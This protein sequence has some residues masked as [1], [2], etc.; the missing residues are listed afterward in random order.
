M[1]I[2]GSYVSESGNESDFRYNP[3]SN[4][5][6]LRNSH[7]QQA[8]VIFLDVQSY[9][10][11]SFVP[12]VFKG[13]LNGAKGLKFW[14]GGTEAFGS[15]MDF[16]DNVWAD[17]LPGPDGVFARID[18]MLMPIITKPIG[19][20][21]TADISPDQRSVIAIGTRDGEDKHY[22]IL[23]NFSET[24]ETVD[25]TLNN[26][27]VTSVKDFFTKEDVGTINGQTLSVSVGHFNEGYLVLELTGVTNAIS[28]TEESSLT[29][30]PNPANDYII[31]E[32][33]GINIKTIELI[34]ITGKIR[35]IYSDPSEYN[36][37]INVSNLSKGMY[38]LKVLTIDNNA[39][40]KKVII[41]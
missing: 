14:R 4:M 10:H 5:S 21:W 1:D 37:R 38:F 16:R 31:I 7:K 28:K 17:A 39:I 22:I 30:Y 29:I 12:S 8:P 35:Y 2:T 15:K 20:N 19:T 13:I 32:N 9:Y 11:Y 40:V 18:S 33:I 25:I 6:L 27:S 24:D 34:D 36:N 23:S 41:K 3:P 26:I